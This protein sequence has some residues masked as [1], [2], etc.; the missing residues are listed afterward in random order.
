MTRRDL[1]FRVFVSSTFRDLIEERNALQGKEK[2]FER[3]RK[4]C[5]ERGARFQ[6]ID[7]RWGV[8]AEAGLDQQTMNICFEE[9]ARCQEMSPKPN[10]IILLG[11]RY[12]WRPLP[13][14]IPADEFDA[15]L[16]RVPEAR[17]ELL[18][19]DETVTPWRD[20]QANDRQGWYRK[21]LNAK[22][23]EYVLQPRTIDFPNDASPD[24]R[25]RIGKEEEADWRKCE[26]AMHVLLVSA[27]D[28]LGWAEDD[29]RRHPYE[30][31]ATHQEI[32]HGALS[33]GLDA[34]QHVFAYF[35]EIAGAP[36]DGSAAEFVDSG[37]DL[38]DLKGLKRELERHLSAGHVY[39]YQ[40]KWKDG[41]PHAD[42]DVLCDRVFD[43]LKR[44]IDAELKDFQQKPELEREKE[45]HREFAKDRSRHFIGRRD[46]LERIK[47]YLAD[48]QDNRPLVI[49]GV[50][51]CGKTALVAQAW[52]KLTDPEQTVARFIGATPG[53]ADLRTLLRSLC[54]Q[55][56]VAA[57]PTDMNEL[58]KAFRER[59]AGAEKGNTEGAQ[60]ALAVVFLDALDQLNPADNSR[61]LYWL[62]RELAPGVKLVISVLETEPQAEK[63]PYREDPFEI[64]LKIWPDRLVAVR[65]LSAKDGEALLKT[66]LDDAGRVL[67]D[68]QRRD[69]LD[70]F[71][72]DGRPLYLKVAFEEARRWRSWEGLP[73]GSG[74]APGLSDSVEGILAD[75]LRRL[76]NPR[77]HG[78]LLVERALG[79]IAAAKNGLTEEELLDVL[80][81]E[82]EVMDDYFSRTPE[83][84]KEIDRLPVVIWSRL[85]ADLKSYMTDRRADGTT[86][87]NFY[88]GQVG[89]SVKARYLAEE[90]TRLGV[91]VRL[92]DYFHGLDYWAESL[93]AQRARAKRLPPTPRP[94]NVRKVVE[95]PYHR[96][97]AAKLGGKDDPKS[98]YWD[99]VADLLTDWQFLEAKTEADPNFREQESQ[100]PA[101]PTDEAKP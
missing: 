87:M 17:I 24:N 52:L 68:D 60:P 88:H 4:Y 41:R 38:D 84:P 71:A 58:V 56:G 18:V 42:L 9:L 1:I 64:S 14:R 95:L 2:T 7:L 32:D 91:H 83:S 93:E 50:S 21:D 3:L 86:V 51:G 70:K 36:A 22:P 6:A 5:Q 47:D 78:R 62:P 72:R 27:M 34:D 31:S 63:G 37:R 76:E 85:R 100:E 20:G 46:V 59:L 29:P 67:Q 69:V 8:S 77:N 45:S 26:A 75:T 94:A 79:S 12:G 53:S 13:A 48:P 55:L 61:M 16:A 81:A 57:P 19:T 28:R 98:K 92:G 33:P 74:A 99:T 11:E 39:R 25:K 66:W 44:I 65:S 73:R 54:E 96:L 82:K 40:A 89:E 43:D 35:R 30:R 90:E 101:A 10:F 97:E 23:P 80:S 49:H 15:L